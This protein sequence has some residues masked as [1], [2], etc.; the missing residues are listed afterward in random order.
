M[1]WRIVRIS[2]KI[3]ATPLIHAALAIKTATKLELVSR[4]KEK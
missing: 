4:E 1:I 3:L 2:E